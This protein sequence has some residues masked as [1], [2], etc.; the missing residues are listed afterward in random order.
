MAIGEKIYKITMVNQ[1]L[2]CK[3]FYSPAENNS[4]THSSW[5]DMAHIQTPDVVYV[6]EY[7]ALIKLSILNGQWK[8][9]ACVV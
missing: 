9:I 8:Q 2:S 7:S 6:S 1:S 4:K 5:K 3:I